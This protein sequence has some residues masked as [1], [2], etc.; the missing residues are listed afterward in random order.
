ML[1]RQDLG[2]IENLIKKSLQEFFETLILPYFEHNETDHAEI[3]ATL[4]AHDK[5]FDDH[6]KRFDTQD[7]SL[8]SLY[9]K[10][11]KNEDDHEEIFGRLDSIDKHIGKQIGRIE[12]LEAIAS[13]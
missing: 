13:T 6:D 12:H 11:E 10:L 9:R 8:D 5:R 7:K 1:N 4:K 3:K 2:S